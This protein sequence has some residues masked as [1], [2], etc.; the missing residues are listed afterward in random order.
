MPYEYII[1]GLQKILNG[2]CH[3]LQQI[4]ILLAEDPRMFEYISVCMY[5]RVC[6]GLLAYDS[7]HFGM[8]ERIYVLMH[9]SII[10]NM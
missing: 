4:R 5:P 6:I 7:M 1:E 2:L 8:Q 10:D 3:S 9:L